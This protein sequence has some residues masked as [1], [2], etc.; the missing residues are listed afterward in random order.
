MEVLTRPQAISSDT[1]TH[2][3]PEGLTIDEMLA[4]VSWD[5]AALDFT[6]VVLGG[7]EIDRRYWNKIRLKPGQRLLIAIR[8]GNF[9]GGGGGM[10]KQI[11]TAVA[12]IAIMVVAWYA[13][14]AIAGAILPSGLSAATV[15][16]VEAGIAAAIGIAGTLALS[17]FVRPPSLS[18]R[19][20]TANPDTGNAPAENSLY[21]VSGG[22]NSIAR[23]GPVPKLFGRARLTPN[24]A[25]DPYVISSGPVQT[26]RM[27]LDFGYGPLKIE[28]IRV[29]TTPISQFPTARYV[30]NQWFGPGNMGLQIYTRDN[31]TLQVGAELQY[32]VEHIRTVPQAGRYIYIDIGMP[33]GLNSFDRNGNIHSKDEYI[34]MMVQQPGYGFASIGDYPHWAL[35]SGEEGASVGGERQVSAA[36]VDVARNSTKQITWRADV[37]EQPQVGQFVRWEGEEFQIIGISDA[38]LSKPPDIDFTVPMNWLT[39]T[40]LPGWIEWNWNGDWSYMSWATQHASPQIIDKGYTAGVG[41]ITVGFGPQPYDVHIDGRSRAG[42]TVTIVV[43]LGQ[44]QMWNVRVVRGTPVSSDPLVS[45][46]LTWVS[47]R[48]EKMSSPFVPREHRTIMELEVAATEQINGQIQNIN[49]LVTSLYWDFRDNV[50]KESRNPAWAYMDLLTRPANKRY[51]SHDKLDTNKIIQWAG[52]CDAIS[53]QGDTTA[54]C[55]LLIESRS[56]VG[57]VAQAICAAGRAIPAMINGKYSVMMEAE[58]RTP[59][60]M[61]TNR[62]T[63]SMTASRTWVDEPHALKVRYLSENTWEREELIVYMDGYGPENAAVFET[64]DL[65]GTTRPW[66]VWRI[67]RYY[68]AQLRLRKETMQIETDIENLVCQRGDLVKVGHDQL[69]NSQN[70]RVVEVIGTKLMLDSDLNNATG[71]IGTLTE[72][73]FRAGTLPSAFVFDRFSIAYNWNGSSW[74]QFANNVPR[75]GAAGEGLLMEIQRTN[76]IRNP[77]MLGGTTGVIGSGGVL[78]S[79]WSLQAARGYTLEYTGNAQITGVDT[80]RFVIGGTGNANA[81]SECQVFVE[82][83][84]VINAT[85]AQVFTFSAF[86]SVEDPSTAPPFGLMVFFRNAS[87]VT[88]YT[89]KS[90]YYAVT[91]TLTRFSFTT[92]T[93]T[94]AAITKVVPMFYWQGGVGLALSCAFR[95]GWPQIENGEL[96]TT[97]MIPTGTGTTTQQVRS[98]DQIFAY[99]T[100]L[101]IPTH[102]ESRHELKFTSVVRTASEHVLFQ[103]DDGSNNNR[104]AIIDNAAANTLDVLIVKA[105]ATMT[106]ATVTAFDP[107]VVN[108]LIVEFEGNGNVHVGLNADDRIGSWPNALTGFYA[109]RLGASQ[110]GDRAMANFQVLTVLAGSTRPAWLGAQIR[111]AW[112]AVLNATPLLSFTN[113]DEIEVHPSIST[114]VQPGDLVS[115]GYMQQVLTDWLVDSISPGADLSA[116]LKLIE[117]RPEINTADSGGIPAYVPPNSVNGAPRA[118]GPARFPY[119]VVG[120]GYEGTTSINSVKLDWSPPTDYRVDFYIVERIF[121]TNVRSLVARTPDTFLIEIIAASTVPAGGAPITYFITPVTQNGRRGQEV[122]VSSWIAPDITPPDTPIIYSNVM[123]DTTR[124]WWTTPSQPDVASFQIRWSP[125]YGNTEWNNMQ[126]LVDSAAPTTTTQMVHTR[127]GVYAIRAVDYTGNWSGVNYTR[128][129]IEMPVIVD[130]S[131][132]ISGPPWTGTLTNVEIGGDGYLRLTKNEFDEYHEF[133][134]FEFTA[135]LTLSQ[136]W[137]LRVNSTIELTVYP[138]PGELTVT[139]D[140]QI[141]VQIAKDLPTL[142]DAWF[143]PLSNA[144]PLAGDPTNFNPYASVVT[145]W[146]EAR[147]YW[148]RV[149]LNSRDGVHT[150]V[151]KTALADFVF[152]P[153]S[154]SKADVTATGGVLEYNYRYAFVQTPGIQFTINNGA[155]GDYITRVR[156]DATGFKIEIRNSSG[157]LTARDVDWIAT[158]IGIG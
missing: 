78:P 134:Y 136:V 9:G 54:T 128:T 152:D 15:G 4:A 67:G 91:T 124:L 85:S 80:A 98:T 68:L 89:V 30:I 61:F 31:A 74:V 56:T 39:L 146:M 37:G 79:N 11:L 132:T 34:H 66:Q 47:L 49:A 93:P 102:G 122:M 29:G 59:V 137:K 14:P 42:R 143:T 46:H 81:G 50:W 117:Y 108:T 69:L 64:L 158:G 19:A 62:N 5:E 118:L 63:R 38:H 35:F 140:A 94:D 157:T 142:D 129:L 18:N 65:V 77:K 116:S 154:E 100:N 120:Q 144:D 53:A 25:V 2:V 20:M 96:L 71:S 90:P 151:V 138:D 52:W 58:T 13:A 36:T 107:S 101:G 12:A 45:N 16:A 109:L 51:V 88:L 70:A 92:T 127:S 135:S 55:D 10:G 1:F 26:L 150:P 22:A 23:Y 6:S 48:S 155:A 121:L 99:T 106:R 40:G 73:D 21:G 41:P 103:I 83:P 44:E 139:H 148:V 156:N 130:P 17:A 115:V 32:M 126:I 141:Q 95:I 82:A 86:L 75:F 7:H 33:G 123:G 3:L 113:T 97:P 110:S 147:I 153:R 76:W 149:M 72:Y 105:G 119:I 57:E 133:G 28:D 24:M 125:D 104:V 131:Y 112:G 111:T 87:N 145:E 60:Q 27:I 8:P 43:D 84:T 114:Q